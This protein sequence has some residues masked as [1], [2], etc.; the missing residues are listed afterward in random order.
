MAACLAD[1]T[2]PA[3]NAVLRRAFPLDG[4]AGFGVLQEK[5]RGRARE[6]ILGNLRDDITSTFAQV[7]LDIVVKC[8]CSRYERAELRCAGKV[9]LDVVACGVRSR[10]GP[11]LLWVYNGHVC[12]PLG[13]WKI[14]LPAGQPF[15]QKPRPPGVAPRGLAANHRLDL[16]RRHDGKESLQD[17]EV[18]TLIFQCEG[19]VAL[20]RRS[21]RVAGGQDPPTG[22]LHCL[23][24]FPRRGK[25]SWQGDSQ[26]I[27]IDEG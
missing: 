19:E 8:G 13:I 12:A 5:E 21:R 27:G 26:A 7:H 1:C 6:E 11:L 17:R 15:V 3:L 4:I 2:R 18:Q 14:E 22:L 20:D 24:T 25:R 16:T 10:D 9:V 23:M